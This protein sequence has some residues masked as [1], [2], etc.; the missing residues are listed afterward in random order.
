MLCVL[1]YVICIA[2]FTYFIRLIHI[3]FICVEKYVQHAV[4]ITY[5]IHTQVTRLYGHTYIFH[6][7]FSF[8]VCLHC[9][10]SKYGLIFLIAGVHLNVNHSV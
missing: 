1:I 5:V 6:L 10:V 8:S 7:A 4:H 9:F 3:A 2:R